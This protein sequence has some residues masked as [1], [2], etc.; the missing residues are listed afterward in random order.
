MDIKDVVHRLRLLAERETTSMKG[1]L[2]HLD[3]ARRRYPEP[4][5]L[6]VMAKVAHDAK[7][8]QACAAVL[9]EAADMIE[10][11]AIKS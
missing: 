4:D 6:N 2:I 5:Y 7:V 9:R 1:E 8:H 3:D 10:K 11:E